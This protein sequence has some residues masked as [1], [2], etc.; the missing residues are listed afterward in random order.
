MQRGRVVRDA[1]GGY[2]LV[3]AAFHPEVLLALRELGQPGRRRRLAP[4]AHSE[5]MAE[6]IT[7][8]CPYC[9]GALDPETPGAV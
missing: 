3:T 6:T 4:L 2:A 8:R 9:G 1:R 5:G 7:T